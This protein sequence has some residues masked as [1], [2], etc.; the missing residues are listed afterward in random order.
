MQVQI[1]SLKSY[2]RKE[3]LCVTPQAVALTSS[4]GWYFYSCEQVVLRPSKRIRFLVF[5]QSDKSARPTDVIPV[6]VSHHSCRIQCEL[7]LESSSRSP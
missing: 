6:S 1:A 7:W 2:T 3:P 4:V 5:P